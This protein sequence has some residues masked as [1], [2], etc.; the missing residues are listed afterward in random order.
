M[1]EENFTKV[2]NN[3]D[4]IYLTIEHYEY[5]EK[6]F[7]NETLTPFHGSHR[8]PVWLPFFGGNSGCESCQGSCAAGYGC[9]GP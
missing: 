9:I 3:N 6:G 4:D 2:K 8:P 1:T 5:C 7:S